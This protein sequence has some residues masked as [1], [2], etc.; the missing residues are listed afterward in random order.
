MPDISSPHAQGRG[1][2]PPAGAASLLK[3]GTL[4][5]QFRVIRRIGR[6][7]MGEVY[8]ARDTRLGRKVALKIVHPERLSSTEAVERFIFEARATARFNHPNIVTLYTAGEH[9]Q[10]PYVALEYLKGETLRA[11]ITSERPGLKESLRIGLAIAEGLKEAHRHGILHRDLKPENVLIPRD[12]RIRVLDFGLAGLLP[13]P[14]IREGEVEPDVVTLDAG[15]STTDEFFVQPLDGIRGSPPYMAPE[16]WKEAEPTD[17]T[18]VWAL[19]I[20]LHELLTGRRP[21]EERSLVELAA[22]VVNPE[23]LPPMENRPEVQEG[24]V[25]P[26]LL[27]LVDRCLIKQ[28]EKRASAAEVAGVLEQILARGRGSY[29]EEQNPFRGLQA[30]GERHC[31]LFFGR[32]AETL[33]FLELLRERAVLPVVGPTGAGKSS[34]VMAGVIPRLRERGRW[35]VLQLRPGTDPFSALASRILS[36]EGGAAASTSLL[37][38]LPQPRT[39]GDLDTAPATGA[40][41]RPVDVEDLA[42]RLSE[43]PSLLGL[44]LRRLAVQESSRVLLFVDQLEELST[45]VED[46]EVRLRFMEALCTA[47]DDYQDPVRVIFT[48]R[49]DF[50]SRLS[51]GAGVR[52]AMSQ[53]TVIRSPDPDALEEILTRPVVAMGYSYD[54]PELCRE[55]ISEVQ[56]EPAALPLL[57]FAASTLWDLRDRRDRLLRREDY[58]KM[59]GVGG[60]LAA[61]ADG[62]L[63]G[64]SDDELLLVRQLLLRLV[65]A[66]GTRRVVPR[67]LLLEGLGPDA[68]RVLIRL[69]HSRLVSVH[70]SLSDPGGDVELELAHE[71]LISTW[72]R[73]TRWLEETREEIGFLQEVRQAAELWQRRGR[74]EELWQG[75]ALGE[76]LRMARRCTTPVPGLVQAF[77]EAGQRKEHRRA[78][79]NRLLLVGAI[80]LLVLASVV[81]YYQKEQAE[82]QRRRA[83]QGRREARRRLSESLLEGARADL[84]AGRWLEARAKLR[85]SL[86]VR[87][88]VG[89][90]ALWKRLRRD[91]TLWRRQMG[92][93]IYDVAFSPDGGTVAVASLDHT[94]YLL[95]ARTR[96]VRRRLR[97]HRDQ[98]WNLAYSPDGRRLASGDSSGKVLL[99]E[100]ASG[101][102]RLLGRLDNAVTCISY[103]PG[104]DRLAAGGTGGQVVVW[105]LNGGTPLVLRGHNSRILAL[106]FSP[107][108]EILASSAMDSTV[109]LWD[110]SGAAVR[111]LEGIWTGSDGLAY[112]PDGKLLATGGADGVLRLRDPRSG[113]VLRKIAGPPE[114]N[115]DLAF[116]PRGQQLALVGRDHKVSL[117]NVKTGRRTQILEGH[118]AEIKGISFGPRGRTLVSAAD[119]NS[120]RL[121]DLGPGLHSPR[122]PPGH[123]APVYGPAFSQDGK[124]L[125]TGGSDGALNVWD[126]ASGKLLRTFPG[127]DEDVIDLAVSP[128]GK[129]LASASRDKTVRIRGLAQGRLRQILQ[130]HYS[131]VLSVAFSPDGKQLA[132]G[133]QDREI[134]LWDLKQGGSRRLKG[135]TGVVMT[136]LYSRDGRR[137]FSAGYDSTIRIWDVVSGR[138]LKLLRGHSAGIFGLALSPDG[139]TL[140]S[141]SRDD[142]IR[143][144]DTRSGRSRV[145]QGFSGQAYHIAFHPGGRLLGAPLAGGT[146]LLLD[147]QGGAPTVLRGHRG[148]V[149]YLRFDPA[150]ERAVT[151]SDDGTVR[152]W[153]TRSGRPLWRCP[154]M[155]GDPP[156]IYAQGGWRRLDGVPAAG[157]SEAWRRAVERR[158]LAGSSAAG[159]TLCLRTGVGHLE[160]WNRAADRRTATLAVP[161]LLR[162]EVVGSGCLALAG[163]EARLYDGQGAFRAL[164]SGVRAIST[165]GAELYLVTRDRVLVLDP[166]GTL[167]AE[168]RV[169][170]GVSAVGR[171]G[172]WL[173]LG[174]EDGAVERIS[175]DS[176]GTRTGTPT[177]LTDLPSSGVTRMLPGPRETL[178]V[179]F[180]SGLL[181]IWD[182]R[183]GERLDSAWLHGPVVH[184][185]LVRDRVYAATELG[186][187]GQLLLEGYRTDYCKLLHQVWDSVPVVWQGGLLRLQPPDEHHRCQKR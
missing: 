61:H 134:R 44:L 62:V 92:A 160:I 171:A 129:W 107:D 8:L 21:F 95:D 53:V 144:W 12:G 13:R 84:L 168:H 126:A 128:D 52:Q 151:T 81:F 2:D 74:D 88:S 159:D 187:Q 165:A 54:D 169:E 148:E 69:T 164:E 112:S 111:V 117:F 68:E 175:A 122:R 105:P 64:L 131:G 87:D 103:G 106:A 119:E 183:S 166:S 124:R 9:G 14:S 177:P 176:G 56:G 7:G 149:N 36:G 150:G 130:G 31:G 110:R 101:Q 26:E 66:E 182:L 79:R 146:A 5:D 75:D 17:R 125:F 156:E 184:L 58:R 99:W 138:Q 48:L 86:E 27:A 120:V 186:D 37:S 23:P 16:Q 71:S 154:V 96:A 34:F 28:P 65:T 142:S 60:A 80:G 67:G 137:L 181:G 4:V 51:R 43:A 139:S 109:R 153:E 115:L 167:R 145:L 22:R 70:R 133:G 163:Q 29:S 97:G 18:D 104:G 91:P 174:F 143:L 42:L 63:E 173:V 178:I 19:G 127:H 72:S 136:V 30:F 35:Q 20:I 85:A 93:M 10:I 6:G 98:V 41:E 46:R 123:G 114:G 147:L 162:T 185:R 180:A 141:S 57:Q 94:V 47:A 49:E 33:E 157:G 39:A 170:Q 90:R 89:G 15:T 77:L 108:G 40:E 113:R 76:A 45:L 82:T 118:T 55:M 78:W 132:T 11:R 158:A 24:A 161:G 73:L 140:A 25:P 3:S 100:L 155:T 121:W 172:R 59:G 179:G 116:D 102:R 135:H 32:D 38:G 152:L 1:I 50:F 83:D